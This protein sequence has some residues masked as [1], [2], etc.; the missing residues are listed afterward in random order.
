MRYKMN[1]YKG[2]TKKSGKAETISI[3]QLQHLKVL[4]GVRQSVKYYEIYE[5]KK[6]V[7]IRT[8]EG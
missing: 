1:V 4:E 8:K 7:E 2:K 6:L 5:G 3:N